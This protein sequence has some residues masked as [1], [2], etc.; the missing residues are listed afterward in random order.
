MFRTRTGVS[1]L[2]G[3][4]DDIDTTYLGETAPRDRA[5]AI[6]LTFCHPS[7]GYLYVGRLR[8][9]LWA[10]LGFLLAP[11]GFIL[12]WAWLKFFPILPMMVFL[13]GWVVMTLMC[14]VGVLRHLK[15]DLNEGRD[16]L[17]RAYNNPIAYIFVAL[18]LTVLPLLGVYQAGTNWLWGVVQINDTSMFPALHVGDALLVDRVA[19]LGSPPD[20]G[21]MVVLAVDTEHANKREVRLGRIIGLA[22]DL[23][24]FEGYEV[25]VNGQRLQRLVYMD[26]PNAETMFIEQN[27]GRSY[28]IAGKAAAP[29]ADAGS[30]PVKV[31]AGRLLVIGDNRTQ[32]ISKRLYWTVTPEQVLGKPRYLL[33]TTG[34]DG[35]DL[36]RSGLKVR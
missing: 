7:L 19:F 29:A 3:T 22:G 36:S 10:G 18:L 28:L 35:L 17:L 12:L 23:V 16:F 30:V 31:A 14:L 27:S 25:L 4:S 26:K 15:T 13:L 21:E 2:T 5:V 34:E 24:T 11:I 9:A 33:Y 8:E 20:R 1:G 6:V 32:A